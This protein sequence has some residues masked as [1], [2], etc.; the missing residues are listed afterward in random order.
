[1][2]IYQAAQSWAVA[3]ETCRI[4]RTEAGEGFTIYVIEVHVPPFTWYVKHRYSNFFDLHELLTANCH[5]DKNLLPPKKLFGSHSETFILKRQA[6]LQLYLQTLIHQFDVLPV[7]LANFLDFPRYEVRT[8]IEDLSERLFYQGDQIL[9]ENQVF[10]FTPLQLHA[11]SE[12]LK[13]AEPTCVSGD[14]KQDLGHL[15]GFISQLKHLRIVGSYEH[16]GTSDIIPNNLTFDLMP[17][18]SLE[19]LD[20]QC[21]ELQDRLLAVEPL[22]KTLTSLAIR[23]SLRDL[24][25]ILL[26]GIIHWSPISSFNQWPCWKF[27]THANFSHNFLTRIHPSVKLLSSVESIDFSFN[28]IHDIENLEDLPHLSFLNMSH[29]K[30]RHL[31]ALHTRLGNVRSLHLDGNMIENLHGLSKLYSVAELYLSDNR[32]LALTEV[33]HLGNLPCLEKLNLENNPINTIVDYRPHVLL[34]FGPRAAEVVL[35][36]EKPSQKEVDTVAVLQALQVA[37]GENSVQNPEKMCSKDRVLL[38]KGTTHCKKDACHTIPH[39]GIIYVERLR[40]VGG[41]DWLRL[42]NQMQKMDLSQ[43]DIS[44][45][46]PGKP[47]SGDPEKSDNNGT[48]ETDSKS[49]SSSPDYCAVSS[50]ICLPEWLLSLDSS[51]QS[52]QQYIQY[53]IQEKIVAVL[54]SSETQTESI[55]ENAL[56]VSQLQELVWSIVA[57]NHGA[58]VSNIPICALLFS[59][60]IVLLKL[61]SLKNVSNSQE[62]LST[63]PGF[64]KLCYMQTLSPMNILGVNIGPRKAYI[65]LQIGSVGGMQLYVFFMPS[66]TVAEKFI[67]IVEN[68]YNLSCVDKQSPF[69]QE[70]LALEELQSCPLLI[71]NSVQRQ[72]LFC[73]RILMSESSLGCSSLGAIHYIAVTPSHI[74]LVE[75]QLSFTPVSGLDSI[76]YPSFQVC[77]V[78][79]VRTNIQN[80]H[81]KDETGAINNES[82]ALESFASSEEGGDGSA[83]KSTEKSLGEL[84]RCGPWLFMEFESGG[85]LCVRFL[86]SV[87]RNDFLGAFLCVRSL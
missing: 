33:A 28:N 29:N 18:K 60:R 7:P 77:M 62:A 58:S 57:M 30:L 31:D 61:E 25:S 8:I 59:A 52:L 46:V 47:I 87:D 80:I 35:D 51:S 34:V 21:C 63:V 17:F 15:L 19:T 79:S 86:N 49:S 11:I 78:V 45:E 14:K 74:L 56:C 20:I 24:S 23:K 16:I 69:I 32:I 70:I 53:L 48:S 9:T 43:R 64:P 50:E 5:V 36:G 82:V 37:R 4:P 1:M 10:Q 22:R 40:K 54:P 6:D 84:H 42:L 71:E 13:L 68:T 26:C 72:I 12:R 65:E 44:G 3:S 83:S 81:L 67:G 66:V 55:K 2:A 85:S 41:N 75:E 76:M 38:S 39:S 73:R 27:V